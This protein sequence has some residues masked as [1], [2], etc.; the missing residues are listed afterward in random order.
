[1]ATGSHDS[2]TDINLCIFWQIANYIKSFQNTF[3][4]KHI[5]SQVMLIVFVISDIHAVPVNCYNFVMMSVL[6]KSSFC[7]NPVYAHL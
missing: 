6:L 3:L 1:M 7:V 4:K 2:D 5:C